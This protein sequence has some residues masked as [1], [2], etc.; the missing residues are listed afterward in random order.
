[1]KYLPNQKFFDQYYNWNLSLK[2]EQ[3]TLLKE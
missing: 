3:Q 1:M 2:T